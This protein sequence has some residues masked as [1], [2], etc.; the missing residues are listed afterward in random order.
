MCDVLGREREEGGLLV[1]EVF[2]QDRAVLGQGGHE[3][4][5]FVGARGGLPGGDRGVQPGQGGRDAFVLGL[6]AQ[7]D[8]GLQV[9]PGKQRRPQ[10]LVLALV[11]VAQ[12]QPVDAEVVG[13]HLGASGVTR[14]DGRDELHQQP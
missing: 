2:Q 8:V 12:A 9:H 4:V 5:A 11:M 7:D 13:D 14:G 1:V 6:H 3:G 10:Q